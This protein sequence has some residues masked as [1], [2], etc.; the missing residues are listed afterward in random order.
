MRGEGGAGMD[1]TTGTVH[2]EDL[3]TVTSNFEKY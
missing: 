3:A 1:R 2:L